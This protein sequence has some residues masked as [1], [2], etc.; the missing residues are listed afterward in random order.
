MPRSGWVYLAIL[1]FV[2]PFTRAETVALAPKTFELGQDGKF[3]PIEEPSASTAPSDDIIQNPELDRIEQLLADKKAGQAN[4]P[5][6]RWIKA[7]PVAPDRDRGLFLLA[8]MYSQIGNKIRAYY[9][10][11]ELMDYYPGSRLFYP[12]LE[13]QY[14]VADAYL[15]GYK[16][17]FLRIPFLSANDEAVEILFRIQ[18]RAPGSPIAERALLRTADYYY[19][20]SQF[21]F[22]ADAYAAYARSY[23][24]S[25]EISRVRLRQAFSS[26]AQFRGLRFDATPVIDAKAQLQDIQAEYPEM[27]QREN[28]ADVLERIDGILAA[29]IAQTADFYRR[30]NQP[31]AAAHNLRYLV[32][33]Y[34]ESPEAAKAQ[35]QLAKMPAWALEIPAP[36]G[37]RSAEEE[38]F[39]PDLPA[40]QPAGKPAAEAA[41]A[42]P[43]VDPVAPST[44]PP[45]NETP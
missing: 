14:A 27:A 10:L 12:S 16:R 31:R 38:R 8:E 17:R 28:V 29:R 9:H 45:S 25:P 34:P 43:S 15:R 35:R 13:K 36:T 22:A 33:N 40:P 20:S 37:G 1:V 5:M 7:N 42:G 3:R 18:E 24:R 21:D 30:T 2:S 11:D 44:I 19:D 32:D 6:I 41:P 23:S 4:G 39:K 26:L